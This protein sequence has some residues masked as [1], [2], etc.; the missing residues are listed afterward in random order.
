MRQAVVVSTARTPIGRAFKGSRNRTKSPTL[1]GHA[2]RHAVLRSGVAPDEIEDV[3]VGTVLATGTA[4]M[5]IACNAGLAGGLPVTTGAQ[6]IDRQCASGLMGVAIG[7]KQIM[8]DGMNMVVAGGQ[9][10]V[11]AVQAQYFKWASSE[12]DPA[13]VAHSVHAYMPL[14]PDSGIRSAQVCNFPR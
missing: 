9:E 2:I 7:A 4:G 6:S 10:N 13:V 8:V 14:S 5:N 11:S 12:A 1:M 3:I